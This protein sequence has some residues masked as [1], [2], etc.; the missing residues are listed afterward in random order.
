[1]KQTSAGPADL[2]P[3]VGSLAQVTH[4]MIDRQP[5][6]LAVAP[7]A[8]RALAGLAVLTLLALAGCQEE[9]ISHY[10]VPKPPVFRMLGAIVP[11]TGMLWFF[12]VSG[13]DEAVQAHA[14]EFAAFI[15]SLKFEDDKPVWT[16]PAGWRQ[17]PGDAMRFATMLLGSREEPLELS[18]SKFDRKEGDNLDEALLHNVNRW[19]SQ[20]GLS[21]IDPEQLKDVAPRKESHGVVSYRV[22]MTGPRSGKTQKG[23]MMAAKRPAEPPPGEPAGNAD[24]PRYTAP[25]DW[26]PVRPDFVSM[27]AFVVSSGGQTAKVTITALGANPGTLLANVNRWR[28]QIG[29]APVGEADLDRLLQKRTVAGSEAITLD[30]AGEG[31]DAQR[32]LVVMLPRGDR[33]WFFKMTGPA[34]LVGRQKSAFE[35]FIRSVRFD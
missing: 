11:R 13:P 2:P 8:R 21:S 20:M 29:L 30:M 15:D 35:E 1:M 26:Q 19:R 4:R 25:A 10:K 23:P 31:S 33:T 34:Q 14:A 17:E 6:P 7:C 16:L 32:I 9:G 18:V 12:K 5:R 22:E 3:A 24:E 28:G 27:A